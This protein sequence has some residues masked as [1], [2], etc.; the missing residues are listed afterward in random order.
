MKRKS[1]KGLQT[2]PLLWHLLLRDT[3]DPAG[4]L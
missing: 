1:K 3:I 2:H 4:V